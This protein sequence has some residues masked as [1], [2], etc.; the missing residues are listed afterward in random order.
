MRAVIV[1]AGIGGLAAA[2][3]LRRVGI[4]VTV[5][6]RAGEIREVG[7]GLSIWANAVKALREL[8]VEE[9]VVRLGS[10]LDRTR[11]VSRAGSVVSEMALPQAGAPSLCVHRGR[12]QR[13]LLEQLP[14]SCIRTGTR[15]TGYSG[16]AALLEDG[17]IR[18]VYV[19]CLPDDNVGIL[20][21][22]PPDALFNPWDK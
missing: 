16:S 4:E 7:A 1:G 11:T 20:K 6:E 17:S 5:I 9:Q 21:L 8:G 19:E 10:I 2:V 22:D 14:A 13:C 3:A 12:L 18:A 15:C